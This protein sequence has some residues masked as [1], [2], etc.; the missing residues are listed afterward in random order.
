MRKIFFLFFLTLILVESNGQL[1]FRNSNIGRLMNFEDLNGHSLLKKSDP[2]VSGSPFM[3]DDWAP[4]KI[5]LS[6]GK[7]IGPLMIKLNIESN[8]LYYLDSAGKEMIAADGIVKKIDCVNFYSKDSIRYVFKNGYP[9]IDKQNENFFYQVL[10]EGKTELLV[11]KSKYIRTTKNDLTGDVT[12]DIVDGADMLYVYANNTMQIYRP[13][14]SFVIQLLKD[15]ESAISS[16]IETH[17]INFKKTAELVML[18]NYYN[19]SGNQ[20]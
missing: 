12:K 1:E 17:K 9:S 2:D 3:R 13:S 7:E 16:Y 5:T 14:K 19:G 15:K 18:F 11:K 20:P 4:A 8:E 10:A 6:K